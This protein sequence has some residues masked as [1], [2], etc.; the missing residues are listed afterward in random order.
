MDEYITDSAQPQASEAASENEEL[1]KIEDNELEENISAPVNTE[2]ESDAADTRATDYEAL[3][4]SDLEELKGEFPELSDIKSL[5]EI[6]NPLR[7][8]ALRDLGLSPTEAYLAAR[9]KVARSDNRSHLSYSVPKSAGSPGGAMSH[10]ELESARELF[11]GMSDSEIQ[12]LY[13]RVTT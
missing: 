8:G 3:M 12:S 11:C 13:K 2:Q 7:Y 9:G 6:K 5:A 1:T 10:S 4:K